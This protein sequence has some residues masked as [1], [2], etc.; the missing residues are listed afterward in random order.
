MDTTKDLTLKAF[1]SVKETIVHK[2]DMHF[3]TEKKGRLSSDLAEVV[4]QKVKSQ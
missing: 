3:N 1:Q 4:E 2:D